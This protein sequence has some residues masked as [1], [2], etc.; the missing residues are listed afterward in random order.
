[1]TEVNHYRHSGSKGVN[2][3]ICGRVPSYQY[4]VYRYQ[5][6]YLSVIPGIKERLMHDS[7]QYIS[8]KRV[9]VKI[10]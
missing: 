8:S 9:N 7:D 5:I 10:C 6:S 3:T 2:V 4:K 1:M